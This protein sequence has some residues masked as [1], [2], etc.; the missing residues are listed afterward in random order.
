M[1]Y[2]CTTYICML[3]YRKIFEEMIPLYMYFDNIHYIHYSVIVNCTL[4]NIWLVN[5][6][7]YIHCTVYSV[8]Y[9]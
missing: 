9:I 7:I 8:Q 2:V 4:Y 1:F 3:I 6:R 5:I